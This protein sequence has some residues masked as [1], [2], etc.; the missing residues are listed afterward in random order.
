MVGFPRPLQMQVM[1]VTA[2]KQYERAVINA[3]HNLNA[4]EFIDV[5]LK[6]TFERTLS[7]VEEQE[8]TT[9]IRRLDGLIEFLEISIPT[10]F[11]SEEKI[12]IDDQDLSQI[13]NYG[14]SIVM[15][16]EPLVSKIRDI[17]SELDSQLEEL[18]N[19]QRLAEIMSVMPEIF[20]EDVGEGPFIY[21]TAGT[22]KLKDTQRFVWQLREATS[23]K[24]YFVEKYAGE[25]TSV[26]LVAAPK[27]LRGMVDQI[28]SSFGFNMIVIPPDLKGRAPE[29]IAQTEQELKKLQEALGTVNVALVPV[30]SGNGLN[31]AKAAEVVSLLEP[32]I[33][34]PMHYKTKESKLELVPLNRFLKEMGLGKVDPLP[35]LKVSRSTVSSE[36][37]VVVLDYKGS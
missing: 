32:G 16:V 27:D 10:M 36:T 31:A 23:E 8:T 30:G 21:I 25:G 35:S 6:Q 12:Q 19:V 15:E 18:Q 28:L 37:R 29:I 33:V 17:R 13:L 20:F 22:M 9:L 3:L 4:V 1:K 2:H 24:Y 5:E 14:Q 34:I 7:V 26:V 11:S